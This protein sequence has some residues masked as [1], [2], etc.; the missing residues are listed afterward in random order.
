MDQYYG[1]DF[2]QNMSDRKEE[3]LTCVSFKDTAFLQMFGLS[4]INAL[5]YFAQ[6]QFYDPLCINEQ[7]KMQARFNELNAQQLD[8]TTMKGIEFSLWYILFEILSYLC[9]CMEP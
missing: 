1:G 2:T 6:S 9:P 4:E 8:M 3:D 7:L 5:D